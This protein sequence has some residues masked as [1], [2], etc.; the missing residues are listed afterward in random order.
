MEEYIFKLI[1]NTKKE[2][3]VKQYPKKQKKL[4]RND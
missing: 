4:I 2:I 1:E 3:L